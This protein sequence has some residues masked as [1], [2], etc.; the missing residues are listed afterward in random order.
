[1]RD[2]VPPSPLR[3]FLLR[4]GR[5]AVA[6][7]MTLAGGFVCAGIVVGY[8]GWVSHSEAEVWEAF[9]VGGIYGLITA[10]N[11]GLVLSIPLSFSRFPSYLLYAAVG[12][13]VPGMAV[14]TF[15]GDEGLMFTWIAS[16]LGYFVA[17]VYAIFDGVARR[18]DAAE[19]K[20]N[21]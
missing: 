19:Q 15:V 21:P 1:M 20:Q 2:A 7:A 16:T 11:L 6:F 12:S 4:V 9:L 18:A 5:V 14:A 13:I 3:R 17:S 10:F 8:S